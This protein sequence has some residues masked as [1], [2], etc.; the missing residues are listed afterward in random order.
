MTFLKSAY[1]IGTSVPGVI[2]P[3]IPTPAIANLLSMQAQMEQT[4]WLAPEE[5]TT[6]QLL[7]SRP[8]LHHAWHTLPYYRE[9]LNAAGFKPGEPIKDIDSWGQI[10][11]L[12]REQLQSF[13]EGFRSHHLPK[14]HGPGQPLRTSG[15]TGRP[16]TVYRN[17]IDRLFWH[18]ITLRDHLWHRRDARA[19]LAI[20][21]KLDSPSA[22]PPPHGK[23]MDDWGQPFAGIY[24]TG[25]AVLLD[26]GSSS[27]QTQAEW[28]RQI[29]P[30]YLLTYPTNVEA[31]AAYF[32]E[33]NIE[34]P[35]LKEIIT[36]SETVTA[37]VREMCRTQWD[38]PIKDMY[39]AQEV[40]YIALQ[41]P[42]T[43]HYHV[44]SESLLV[45]VLDPF[46]RNC[47]PGEVGR[48]VVTTLHSFASP[49]IR[50]DIGD[51]AEVGEPCPCGRGLPVL[52]R[53]MGRTR[54]ML[55]YPNGDKFW[56][57][58]RP[59]HYSRIA[60]VR[61]VQMIQQTRELIEVRLVTASLLSLHQ[62]KV[63]RRAIQE[64]LGYPF[65]L[66]FKYFEQIPRSPGGKFEEF[67]SYAS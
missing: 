43:E 51:Y 19:K 56:P 1:D 30:D 63:L 37:E 44:Q 54:N 7:Q 5:L 3:A 20:I 6:R 48:V 26:I 39:S 47:L 11:I 45:E 16:V 64:S 41:C 35:R 24:V 59:S 66:D 55:T 25:P 65:Q 31:L 2:W 22:A 40:G 10:P 46:G 53:I 57:V 13:G 18:A 14:G 27:I 60:P 67:I 15:S 52:K 50:Y 38:V 61:Q 8:L 12:S 28:L 42:E 32:D 49:L 34:K 23:A 17:N 36:L 9:G 58:V 62:E 21:R 4:Q 33:H 29:N